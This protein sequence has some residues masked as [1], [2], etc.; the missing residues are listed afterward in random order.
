M[1]I[2]KKKIL[3]VICFVAAVI[4][5]ILVFLKLHQ[6]DK[7]STEFKD[8]GREDTIL[9][10]G[11]EYCYDDHLSNYLFMGVD[12]RE[13]EEESQVRG[14][15]GRADAI[16]LLSYN[17]VKR[18]VKVFSIPRDTMTSIRA[19]SADGTDIGLIKEHIN[20]HQTMHAQYQLE[21]IIDSGIYKYRNKCVYIEQPYYQIVEKGKEKEIHVYS[22]WNKYEL[23]IKT[24]YK[25]L[26]HKEKYEV[27][28][29]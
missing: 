11:K 1:N 6:G 20:M 24:Y 5:L 22:S 10:G 23:M 19:Y 12:T 27:K 25:N 28:Y 15:N 4:C 29:E 16:Y 3:V 17:R 9:Y 2:K 26:H 13:Q 8:N 21:K 14:E 7:Y 18:T